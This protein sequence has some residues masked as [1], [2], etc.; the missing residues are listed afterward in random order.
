MSWLRTAEAEATRYSLFAA[1]HTL[2]T[3]LFLACFSPILASSRVC[4][5]SSVT[6][7]LLT[8]IMDPPSVTAA[9]DPR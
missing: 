7:N 8:R 5:V 4:F 2:P 3:F 9:F 1:R 6:W